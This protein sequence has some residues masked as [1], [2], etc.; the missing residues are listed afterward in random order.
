MSE[1]KEEINVTCPL[2][3]GFT[4]ILLNL[5]GQGYTYIIVDYSGGGDD[6]CIDDIRIIR[7]EIDMSERVDFDSL[8]NFELDNDLSIHIQDI[9]FDKI[10][11]HASDWYNNEGG[12]GQ[13]IISTADGEYISHHY[14]YYQSTH[15]ET[16]TGKLKDF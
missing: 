9:C 3:S 14:T 11:N 6:G 7:D 15:E 1:K 5:L 12:G 2:D 13:L 4:H 16:L 10:L 8:Y